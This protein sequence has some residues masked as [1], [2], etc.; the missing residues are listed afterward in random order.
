IEPFSHFWRSRADLVDVF[1]RESPE[2]RKTVQE[3]KPAPDV[4]AGLLDD[5]VFMNRLKQHKTRLEACFV[6]IDPNTGEVKAWV[7]SRDFERDQYDHGAQ[8]LRQPGSTFKPL[9]YGAALEHGFNPMRSYL[10]TRTDIRTREGD[11]W[12]PGD[13]GTP[14]EMPMTMRDGLILSRNTITAQVMQDVGIADIVA[15]AKA[16]GVN[17]SRLDPV[18]SLALGTSPV[19]LLEMVSAYS[20]IAS[21][22]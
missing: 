22:G 21:V 18:P 19:S 9:V 10:D 20:T 4:M 6:A 3:G 14:T 15:L 16:A 2:F 5:E 11:S 12:R 7:G 8:A 13:M 1:I 17:R